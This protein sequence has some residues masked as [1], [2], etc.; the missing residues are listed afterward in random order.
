[1]SWE[2]GPEAADEAQGDEVC[3]GAVLLL[4]VVVARAARVSRESTCS[5][6]VWCDI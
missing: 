5:A 1:M 4:L 3:Y 2:H 6:L